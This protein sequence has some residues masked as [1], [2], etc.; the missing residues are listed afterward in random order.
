MNLVD[1]FGLIWVTTNYEYPKT[2]NLLRGVGNWIGREIGIGLDPVV[3]FSSP[4]DYTGLSR[5]VVQE[6][7]PDPDNPCKDKEHA[8]GT[9]RKIH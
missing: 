6:W 3:P 7:Q 2:N 4:A 5:N 1:P 8:Y 9:K